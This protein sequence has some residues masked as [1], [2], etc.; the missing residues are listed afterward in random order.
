MTV[1]MTSTDQQPFASG[2]ALG[3]SEVDSMGNYIGEP[4][5]QY[6]YSTGSVLSSSAQP[7]TLSFS[8]N[9]TFTK[10]NII[11]FF[12]IVGS[13]TEGWEFRVFFDSA[14]MNSFATLPVLASPI[15]EYPQTGIVATMA[16]MVL[17]TYFLARRRQ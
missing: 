9:Q 17:C 15:P 4:M 16:I 2:Y 8:V 5:Y 7:I 3:L 10:G 6:Y 12:V 14:D 11:G 1:W 13:T